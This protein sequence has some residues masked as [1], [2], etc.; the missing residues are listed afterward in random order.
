MLLFAASGVF[1]QLQDALDTI[2]EVTPKPGKAAFFSFLRKRFLSFAMVLGICFLLLVSLVLSAGCRGAAAATPTGEVQGLA[3]RL[4]ASRTSS[5]SL[6]IVTVLFAMIFKILPDATVAWRDV[7]LGAPLTAGLFTL[8]KF[9]IG[10]YLGRGSFGD[11]L[12]RRR[13]AGRPAGVGLLLGADPLP[14]GGVHQGVVAPRRPRRRP[15]GDRR[16]GDRGGAAQEG[17]PHREVVEATAKVLEE[18]ESEGSGA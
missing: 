9:A 4:D 11:V 16:A 15:R 7:W 8:G 2:W 13:L 12:R 5:L 18:R 3:T 17:I 1:A 10:T 6:A 14:G